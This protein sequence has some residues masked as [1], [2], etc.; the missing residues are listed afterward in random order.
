M[1]SPLP[2]CCPLPCAALQVLSENSS[3]LKALLSFVF[4]RV[5]FT[6][7][8]SLVGFLVGFCGGAST[9]ALLVSSSRWAQ[10]VQDLTRELGL[11]AHLT[12]R[13]ASLLCSSQGGLSVSWGH[14]GP[15]LMASSSSFL[16]SPLFFCPLS[17]TCGLACCWGG[18]LCG[19]TCA[20]A[21]SLLSYLLQCRRGWGGTQPDLLLCSL[22]AR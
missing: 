21:D 11:V 10:W 6:C 13:T 5:T 14:P 7:D 19:G 18:R 4:A 8:H 17:S 1:P 22:L 15:D 9:E 12:C 16:Q 20:K 2:Q 3:G